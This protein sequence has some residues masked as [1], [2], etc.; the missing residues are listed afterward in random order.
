VSRLA[1]AVEVQRDAMRRW[2]VAEDREREERHRLAGLLDV[3]ASELIV[4]AAEVLYACGVEDVD[5]PRHR[6]GTIS[7][8]H[9][10]Y[11]CQPRAD[12]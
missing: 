9:T 11:R 4:T 5:R 6:R 8:G 1:A 10:I 7:P 3:G 2:Q 12:L